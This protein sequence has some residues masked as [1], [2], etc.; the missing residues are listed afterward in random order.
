VFLHC[1]SQRHVSAVAMSSLQVDHFVSLQ[2]KPYNYQCY[3]I[4]IDEISCNI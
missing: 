1:F 2:G 3:V 4:V